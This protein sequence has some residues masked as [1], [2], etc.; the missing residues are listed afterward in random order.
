MGQNLYFYSN[1]R[2]S[3]EIQIN[4]REKNKDDNEIFED[5]EEIKEDIY[6]GIGIKKMKGY[7]CTL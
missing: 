6:V 7:K 1:N 5:M 2:K 4:S 3:H